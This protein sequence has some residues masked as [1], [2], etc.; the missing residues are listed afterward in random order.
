[1]NTQ[2]KTGGYWGKP[3]ATIAEIVFARNEVARLVRLL[4]AHNK[5]REA[6]EYRL[7]NEECNK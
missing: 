4:D 2:I 6:D 3:N 7:I 1:M 5:E